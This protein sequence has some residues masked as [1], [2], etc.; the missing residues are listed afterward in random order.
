MKQEITKANHYY[1]YRL[2]RETCLKDIQN[3]T[4]S[5]TVIPIPQTLMETQE[6]EICE[7]SLELSV[8]DTL[9]MIFNITARYI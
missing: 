1:R 6:K 4:N 9:I 7:H 8:K 2:I 3:P 5:P